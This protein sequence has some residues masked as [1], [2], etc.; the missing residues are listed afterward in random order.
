MEAPKD[1]VLK[2]IVPTRD[3][4]SFLMQV[5]NKQSEENI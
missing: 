4:V 1:V 3:L 5:K 2:S